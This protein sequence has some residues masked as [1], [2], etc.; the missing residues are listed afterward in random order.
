MDSGAVIVEYDAHSD[1]TRAPE[2]TT[3]TFAVSSV[4]NRASGKRRPFHEAVEEGLVI[5]EEGMYV[6]TL[7]GDKMLLVDAMK[8]QWVRAKVVE[9]PSM[10]D[11]YMSRMRSASVE[12]LES[13]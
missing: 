12:S 6:D 9:D 13:V 8:K 10:I 11:S 3:K 5:K 4:L 2:V 1:V 7:T